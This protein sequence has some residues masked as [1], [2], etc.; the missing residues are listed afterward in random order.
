MSYDTGWPIERFHEVTPEQEVIRRQ[1]ATLVREAVER[2]DAGL[3]SVI[4]LR[5]FDG[6]SGAETAIRLGICTYAVHTMAY[7]GRAIIREYLKERGVRW[8]HLT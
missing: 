7:K 1:H 5:Y 2:L 3:R 6:L 4:K 8:D